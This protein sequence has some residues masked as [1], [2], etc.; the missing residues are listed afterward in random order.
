MPWEENPGADSF[1]CLP[2]QVKEPQVV[3]GTLLDLHSGS[4]KINMLLARTEKS[5][6]S[7]IACT[8]I[9]KWK[10]FQRVIF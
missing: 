5:S 7:A 10:R 2:S 9:Q 6:S 8:M 3:N 4:A 1:E